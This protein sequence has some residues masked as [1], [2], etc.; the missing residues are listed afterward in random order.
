MQGS[1]REWTV[2]IQ[3]KDPWKRSSTEICGPAAL[4]HSLADIQCNHQ[5]RAWPVFVAIDKRCT[6]IRNGEESHWYRGEA[7][8][9]RETDKLEDILEREKHNKNELES[10]DRKKS[11]K[12]EKQ[13][14]SAED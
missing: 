3:S 9:A 5:I 2:Q 7:V 4:Q 10:K 13:K 8:R 6:Q 14:A 1:A 11:S 12:E